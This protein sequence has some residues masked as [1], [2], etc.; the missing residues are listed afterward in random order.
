MGHRRLKCRRMLLK[1][2]VEI[3][4]GKSGDGPSEVEILKDGGKY[5]TCQFGVARAV[6]AHRR[7]KGEFQL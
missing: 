3:S 4:R 7:L 6:M 2:Q 5:A 1:K